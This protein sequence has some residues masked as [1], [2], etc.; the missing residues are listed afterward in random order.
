MHRSGC[1]IH[2]SAWGG[3]VT[4]ML[5]LGEPSKGKLTT[6]CMCGCSVP[7][8]APQISTLP[9]VWGKKDTPD[10]GGEFVQDGLLGGTGCVVPVRDKTGQQGF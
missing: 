1:F 2:K 6:R 8:C 3:G 7:A 10:Q 9:W 5:V 4:S